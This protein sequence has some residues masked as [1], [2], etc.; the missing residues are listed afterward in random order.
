M[1]VKNELEHN[2]RFRYQTVFWIQNLLVDL[3]IPDF[4]FLPTELFTDFLT[5]K[6]SEIFG[7]IIQIFWKERELE[8][9]KKYIDSFTL[10]RK[11]YLISSGIT[12]LLEL[13]PSG[14]INNTIG[15]FINPYSMYYYEVLYKKY[16]DK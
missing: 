14:I 3:V 11:Y 2:K 16:R 10:K 7:F 15:V 6:L 5:P 13:D 12:L 8:E 4:W 9:Y 1:G